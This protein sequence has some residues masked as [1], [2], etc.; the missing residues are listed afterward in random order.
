ML[1]VHRQ[2]ISE[3]FPDRIWLLR[4]QT[5]KKKLV[6][7]ETNQKENKCLGLWEMSSGNSE[8]GKSLDLAQGQGKWESKGKDGAFSG[9][10]LFH[11]PLASHLGFLTIPSTHCFLLR[12]LGLR[13]SEAAL[14]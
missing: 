6:S 7:K 8:N 10:L 14:W 9:L 5:E 13:E 3:K 11:V 12:F 1:E 2:K 4:N